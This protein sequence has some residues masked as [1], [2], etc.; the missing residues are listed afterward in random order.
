MVTRNIRDQG[1]V[2]SDIDCGEYQPHFAE[3]CGSV[4]LGCAFDE[5]YKVLGKGFATFTN[6][7]DKPKPWDAYLKNKLGKKGGMD[8]DM[9][10]VS[11]E[12]DFNPQFILDILHELWKEREAM[13]ITSQSAIQRFIGWDFEMSKIDGSDNLYEGWRLVMEKMDDGTDLIS[14]QAGQFTLTKETAQLQGID[15]GPIKHTFKVELS[16][17]PF[18]RKK[19][20]MNMTN[21]RSGIRTGLSDYEF[22]LKIKSR[23]F[24]KMNYPAASRRGIKTV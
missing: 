9:T 23:S 24:R 1:F 16:A 22:R 15:F 5:V 2:E 14:L 19:R 21:R 4:A 11:L 10:L 18:F 20:R 12:D 6:N 3:V 7:Y 8:L 13:E 17:I